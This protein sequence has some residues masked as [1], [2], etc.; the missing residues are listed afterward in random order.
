[1][2]RSKAFDVVVV[3]GGAAG[4]VVAARLAERASQSV[5]LLEAGPDRRS[6]LPDDMRDGWTIRS[7]QFD[8]GYTSE[9]DAAGVEH[10]VRRTKLLGGTSWLTRFTPRGHPAD[11]DAWAALGNTGWSFDDV[12]PY[13]VRLETDLDFGDQPWHG[14]R[15]P[16]PSTRYLDLEYMEIGAAA[17]E[18]LV[19]A[20]FPLVDDH[21][22]PGAVGAGRM[23]MNS[24]DGVRV[25]T[26]GAYL[27]AG[28]TPPNLTIQADTQVDR[29]VLE[30]VQACAVRLCDGTVI[31]AGW[32]VLCAG[33]YGS[34]PILMR[35]GIG[36]AEH[37]RGLDVPV[38]VDLPGVGEN[39]ADHPSVWVESGY[40]GIGRSAPVLQS[41]AT[42]HSARRST[43]DTPDLMFWLCDPV[44][45]AGAPASFDIDI[46][47]LRPDARGRVRLRSRDPVESPSIELPALSQRDVERLIEAYRR[48]VEVAN[49]PEVRRLCSGPAPAEP[50]SSQLETY[51]RTEAYSLP[52]VVGTCAM[53]L[54]PED[55]AVVDPSGRVHGTDRL[56][57]VDASI[58]PDVPSGFTHIPTIM[59]AERL[60][61]QLASLR[62]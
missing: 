15:G 47:L 24:R 17:L 7:D 19:A 35:S 62:V 12:L 58:M 38:V 13:F 14:N 51:V 8:W 9:P 41:I 16:M 21:N 42:F 11:Y 48:A 36:S 18:A 59:I 55:G 54:R 3:G 56:S 2:A 28:K 20:G 32:V 57:V 26:A 31:E 30:R 5:L 23:P 10:N 40:S 33:T 4:C 46:V 39:L 60:S 49:R 25:T 29:V 52:H 27:P 22:R 6:D 44:G 45:S 61:E 37:L 34:P 1:M 50:S 53:G 43:E